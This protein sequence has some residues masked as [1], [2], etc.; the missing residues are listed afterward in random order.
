[1]SATLELTQ[2]LVARASVTPTDGGC[3]DLMA[4][5][6][7]RLGFSIERLRYG[8]VENLWARRGESGPLLCFAGDRK[9]VV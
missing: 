1:M 4:E 7:A 3:Q 2:Q 8:N 6:L 5:R 9:S